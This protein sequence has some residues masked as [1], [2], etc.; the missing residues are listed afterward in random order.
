M[1]TL[2]LL[3]AFVGLSSWKPAASEL[4]IIVNPQNN[5]EK[6]TLTQV[7]SYWMRKG[8]QKTWPQ[9]NIVTDPVDRKDKSEE[10]ALFYT[11]VIG[12]GEAD[13]E[14]YF[15]A[16]Q[17]QSGEKPPVRLSSDEEIINY[18]TEHKGAI[19]FV[20]AASLVGDKTSKV[21]VVFTLAP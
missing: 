7:K 19:A 13:V 11:K 5:V 9:L 12:L 17:Y 21:K 14:A 16:K 1:K 6:L 3:V 18:V 4:A 15:S 20:K 2:I 8:A 10:K